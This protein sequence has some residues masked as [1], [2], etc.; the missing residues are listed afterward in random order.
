MGEC[1]QIQVK[2]RLMKTHHQFNVVAL[3]FGATVL[4]ALVLMLTGFVGLLLVSLNNHGMET[5][6]L[7]HLLSGLC[8]FGF[9]W[10]ALRLYALTG[11]TS[12]WYDRSMRYPPPESEALKFF[13]SKYDFTWTLGALMKIPTYL[14]FLGSAYEIQRLNMAVPY[15]G[16]WLI[17]P[18]MTILVLICH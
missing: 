12:D 9:S 15:G 7:V 16:V 2:V 10:F 13:V 14:L 17:M 8:A 18:I 5:T 11:L 1:G 6:R 4:P 3:W